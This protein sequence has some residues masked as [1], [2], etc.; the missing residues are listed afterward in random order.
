[1]QNARK[2]GMV[3]MRPGD[4]HGNWGATGITRDLNARLTWR[5]EMTMY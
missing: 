1:M 5:P 3:C 4:V 2:H